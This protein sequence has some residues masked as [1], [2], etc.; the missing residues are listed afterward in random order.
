MKIHMDYLEGKAEKLERDR[1]VGEA[2]QEALQAQVD[3]LQ[4]KVKLLREDRDDKDA[5]ARK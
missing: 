5:L 4:D 3:S 1:K 2:S